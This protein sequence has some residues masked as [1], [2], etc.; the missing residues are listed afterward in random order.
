[1]N[2]HSGAAREQVKSVERDSKTQKTGNRIVNLRRQGQGHGR[3][4][5]SERTVYAADLKHKT[6]KKKQ[7]LKERSSLKIMSS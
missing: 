6:E 4:R 5:A 1:M 3:E 7:H 2:S